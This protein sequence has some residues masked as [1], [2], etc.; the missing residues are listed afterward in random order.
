MGDNRDVSFDSRVPKFGLVD[1]GS[2]V[3]KPLYVFQSS[4]AGMSI[5]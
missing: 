3:G 1:S 4:R 5:R 2:I